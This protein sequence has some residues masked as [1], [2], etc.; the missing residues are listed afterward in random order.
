LYH[1]ELVRSALGKKPFDMVI[2]NTRLVNVFTGEILEA[3]IGISSGYVAYVG[4]AGEHLDAHHYLDA[5]GRFAVPGL[6]DAHMHIESSMVTPAAFAQGVL[7]HGTTVVAADPHEIANVIGV[8]GIK[9]MISASK[10]LPLKIYTLV[11]TCVPS[12]PGMENAGADLGA[13]EVE[14]VLALENVIGLAEVMDFW[15]V[16]NLEPKMTGILDVAR[17]REGLIEGHCPVFTGRELQAYIAAG[18]DSDHT[19]MDVKKAQEK[20]RL[21][22]TVEI[23][24]KSI[25]PELMQYIESLPDSSN[26]LLVTDDVMADKLVYQGQLDA[27]IRK[28]IQCGLSPIKAIQAATIRPARRLRLYKHGAIGPGKVA[29]ILLL[30]SLEDFS[31]HTVIADG[32]LVAE[33]GRLVKPIELNRFPAE[34]YNTVKLE[35]LTASDFT[36]K[37]SKA[38]GTARIRAIKVNPVTT[39]TDIQEVTVPI[40]DGIIDTQA[41]GLCAIAVFERHGRKG[42]RSMGF[43]EGTG[44]VR[45]AMATTYAHDSHNLSVIGTNP[46]DMALA[47]NTLIKCGGGMA[48]V[49]DGK[50][51]SLVEL[52]IAGLLSDKPMDE[53][54][55]KLAHFRTTLHD[56]GVCHKKPIMMLACLTLPVSPKVKMTDL[57]MVDVVSK[58]F[59]D[60]IIED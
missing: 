32:E 31:I 48:A 27:L 6:V 57:G 11:P 40:K 18:V 16:V 3:T 47:A 44:I 51:L 20:L 60:V 23:Q 26:F 2:T 58:E 29:D 59:L 17:R 13:A 15:S 1:S 30:D 14:E 33:D 25:T 21:G 49:K 56:M 12:L 52:P 4:Y 35:E 22:M 8:E 37:T 19:L 42:S 50:V 28:A 38:S 9:M 10:N 34:A 43:I 39:E 7:P 41:S 53:V 45:G 54:A 24:E 55:K 36:F 5:Q 46:E